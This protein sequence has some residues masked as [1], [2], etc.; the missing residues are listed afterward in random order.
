MLLYTLE[1]IEIDVSR[2][3]LKFG[4]VAR[5]TPEKFSS[6]LSGYIHSSIGR[7]ASSISGGKFH[8]WHQKQMQWLLHISI[9]T[10]YH[11]CGY[12]MYVCVGVYV[13]VVVTCVQYKG[14]QISASFIQW[15]LTCT[16]AHTRYSWH[17][18][19][20]TYTKRILDRCHVYVV[21]PKYS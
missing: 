15:S 17:H 19:T 13:H 3:V 18:C 8:V 7:H 10:T 14:Y 16:Y 1:L 6:Q 12:N 11:I 9:C 5:V 21:D 4:C 20:H 2:L